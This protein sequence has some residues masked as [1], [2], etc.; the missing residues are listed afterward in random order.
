MKLFNVSYSTANR[1]IRWLQSKNLTVPSKGKKKRLQFA[2]QGRDL[3]EA[4]IIYLTTPVEKVVYTNTIPSKALSTVISDGSEVEP[5]EVNSYALCKD[6]LKDITVSDTGRFKIEIWKYNPMDLARL[7]KHVDKLSRYLSI[8]DKEDMSDK[9]EMML[10]E[11][12]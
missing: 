4:S 1:A 9:I 11:L 3:W 7:K 10:A 8:R 5:I 2:K 12:Q 6:D